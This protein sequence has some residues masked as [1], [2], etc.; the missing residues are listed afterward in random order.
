M[1]FVL[2]KPKKEGEP[3]WVSPWGEGRP[4]WHIECSEMSKKYIGDTIDIHAGGEDLVF[5][6]HENEIAQSE[7]CND[8][9]FANYWMHNAF[10]NIDNK[11]MSKSA[12]NF[13]TVREIS[14]KY[15]LQVIRF[16]MLSAHYRSPLNFSDTLV[17]ASKN[18]LERILT[19]V[20]HLRE[21]LT[22][23]PEGEL[24][25]EDQKHMEEVTSLKEKYEAAMEDDFNTA[26]AI[27]AIFELVKL[28]N[29]TAESGS[30]AYVQHLFDTIVQLCDILGII[31]EK[32]EEL[33]ETCLKGIAEHF[34]LTE[35]ELRG[36]SSL[37]LAYIGDCIFELF[38]RT[39]VVTKGNDK[40][41]H[42]HQK[43][44]GYVN[45]AAQTEMME[46]IKPLLTD[47]EK[48]V[49]RRGKNAK[50]LSPAKNQ[51]SHDYH[52]ATGFEALMG[53]LYLSGQMERLEELI[54]ICLSE[55]ANR[56]EE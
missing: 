51:S 19:A 45:A 14:E 18:G 27:A 9:K 11:K 40:A 15:P 30:K 8:E 52:I 21:V 22:A 32:K 38:V 25:A 26:D 24:T 16:F 47:E 34:P 12:G 43:T 3:A 46:I 37:G 48:A 23:A 1:D 33:L 42:Y 2:W 6:H 53:Y 39:M 54:R 4:G 28:A 7:A 29:I 41:N 49:F 5:P 20:D 35:K 17:E 56:N 50:S 44:I 10:L 36:Y 55:K 13:F 31:T